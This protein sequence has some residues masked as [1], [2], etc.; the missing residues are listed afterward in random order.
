MTQSTNLPQRRKLPHAIPLWVGQGAR[1]FITINCQERGTDSLCRDNVAAE[2]LDSARYYEEIGHWYLWLMVV[3]P[4]HVHFIATF[5]LD[6]GL[7]A[8]LKGWKGYQK[9]TLNIEWQSDFFEHR[10]RDEDEFIEKMHYIRMNP[11]RKGLVTSFD[12]WPHTLVRSDGVAGAV[13]F[14]GAKPSSLRSPSGGEGPAEPSCFGRAK[15]PAEPSCH[16]A[17][18]G[19]LAP[20]VGEEAEN[21]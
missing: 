8:T 5:D 15:P 11:V 4:D 18:Q 17:R 21:D 6:R 7:H 1:H 20:P 19:R 14:G 9:R 13:L 2:L 3:M 12:E 10:L 16:A